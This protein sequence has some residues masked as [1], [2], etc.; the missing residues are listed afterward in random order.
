[1]ENNTVKKIVLITM[2]A[3]LLNA[4][5][6][7][8]RVYLDSND[9]SNILDASGNPRPTHGNWIT[10]A[11]PLTELIQSYVEC[12]LATVSQ[13]TLRDMGIT[14][15]VEIR[16]C[17]PAE[18]IQ[19]A[20]LYAI[21]LSSI[22][23]KIEPG[24]IGE[25]IQ[26]VVMAGTKVIAIIVVASAVA[27]FTA[28]YYTTTALQDVVVGE[29]LRSIPRGLPLPKTW[30]KDRPQ[31]IPW[32]AMDKPAWHALV[33]HGTYAC[34]AFAARNIVPDMVYF[35]PGSPQKGQNA[36]SLLFLWDAERVMLGAGKDFGACATLGMG[37]QKE[38]AGDD[39]IP[40]VADVYLAFIVGQDKHTMRYFTITAYDIEKW[41]LQTHLC[42]WNYTE[43]LYPTVELVKC[44]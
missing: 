44:W 3:I 14:E 41:A 16:I 40:A 30:S 34:I 12:P 24:P 1:M 39:V 2:L 33:K 22:P 17:S 9:P 38:Y 15:T 31:D 7:P 4:C 18:E 6:T 43:K 20:G 37:L 26:G 19:L 35:S 36:P 32:E 27:Y 13:E 21:S 23:A 5:A 42:D 11:N 8:N 10:E 25:S 29:D 28:E